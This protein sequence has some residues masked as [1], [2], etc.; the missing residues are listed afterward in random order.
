M[1]TTIKEISAILVIGSGFAAAFGCLLGLCV[2]LLR[3]KDIPLKVL[4]VDYGTDLLPTVIA[5][6][7]IS[8]AIFVTALAGYLLRSKNS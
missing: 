5:F 2:W 8:P 3:D 4:G 7:I 6:A 1:K